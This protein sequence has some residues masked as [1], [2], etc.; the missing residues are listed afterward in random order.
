MT[1]LFLAFCSIL[2][3]SQVNSAAQ[4]LLSAGGS[5]FQQN[6]NEGQTTPE[7]EEARSLNE[8]VIQLFKAG[9]VDEALV[10]AKRVLQL[11]EKA[12]GQ[13]HQLVSEAL[14]NLAELYL[15]KKSYKEA[16]PVYERV[17]KANERLAGM[18]DASNALL[19]DKTAFLRYMTKDFSGAENDY[20]RALSINEKVAG[21]ESEQAAQSAYRL[22]EFYRFNNSYRKA[23]P[24][25]QRALST[26]EKSLGAESPKLITVLESYACFLSRMNKEGESNAAWR[27][28]SVIRTRM[29]NEKMRA[30]K[31]LPIEGEQFNS[32][33]PVSKPQPIYP[34][35]AKRGRLIGL[36]TVRVTIDGA[37]R[38]V[39]A[40]GSGAD[41]ILLEAAEQ[42]ALHAR[43]T[44]LIIEGI[45]VETTSIITYSFTMR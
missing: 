11:R 20:K 5:A 37:G 13:D 9:K 3:L 29:I 42:A 14:I 32:S 10:A 25:Y 4:A 24:F 33:Q 1:R 23:G 45:P 12:L 40:C 31:A 2:L 36:V 21:P 27:R 34:E 7:L 43:F 39:R 22:A 17:L 44:P 18:D 41:P 8:K 16:L 15:A 19:L 38:V 35:E 6:S 30:R 26:M 28:A